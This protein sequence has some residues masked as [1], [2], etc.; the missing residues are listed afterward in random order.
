LK[1]AWNTALRF[2]RPIAIFMLDIDSFKN[3]NDTYGHQA[4]DDCL[5]AI[6]NLL[7]Q[8]IRRASDLAARYGGEEF[9]VILQE[10]EQEKLLGFAQ[11]IRKSVQELGIEHKQSPYEKVTVSVGIACMIPTVEAEPAELVEA[12][13][14]ALYQAKQ[15]GRNRVETSGDV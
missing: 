8:K 10:P 7:S 13:D 15:K 9:V 11:E 12:A 4:G 1:T 5:K 2:Q 6:G 14:R 3:Y